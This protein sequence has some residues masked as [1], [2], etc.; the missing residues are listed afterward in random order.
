MIEIKNLKILHWECNYNLIFKQILKN[1]QHFHKKILVS[2]ICTKKNSE[3]SK[4][5]WQ[6]DKFV[7][8]LVTK[9]ISLLNILLTKIKNHQ[10][11][12]KKGEAKSYIYRWSKGMA[13]MGQDNKIYS[14]QLLSV[15][16]FRRKLCP[17]RHC[18]I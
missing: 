1:H 2:K 18:L 3:P 10:G 12:E 17:N 9:K 8:Y 7:K 13:T 6:N 4:N 11:N 5:N 15:G 14:S 16:F